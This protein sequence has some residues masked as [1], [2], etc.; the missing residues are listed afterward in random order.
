VVPQRS[1]GT[2]RRSGALGPGGAGPDGVEPGDA[3][4]GDV[5]PGADSG[6]ADS[7]GADS[8]GADLGEVPPFERPLTVLE[9][10][11][12]VRARGLA[13]LGLESVGDLLFFTPRRLER[14]AGLLT[15]REVA[16]HAGERASVLGTLAPPR[17][18][19]RGRRAVLASVVRDDHGTLE[20]RWFNQPWMRER[21]RAAAVAKRPVELTG[22][23][24]ETRS[25]VTLSTP[26]LVED[27][28]GAGGAS[29]EGSRG[30]VELV[31][32]Y[33]AT[34]GIGQTLL[35]RLVRQALE[36]AAAGL[37]EPL[38][39]AVR[40]PSGLPALADAVRD[41][42][43]PATVEAHVAARRRIALERLLALQARL[44][45]A[46][47]PG[48]RRR[49]R[50]VALAP[51]ERAELERRLPFPPT[52]GQRAV[53]GEILADLASAAPMRRLLQGEVG[54]GKTLVALAAAAAVARGGGQVALL[55]PTEILAEQHHLGLSRWLRQLGLAATL[56]TGSL[57]PA[58]RRRALRTIEEGQA[59]V[60][61]GTHALLS[62]GVRFRSLDLV[63]IDE[64]QRFGVAQKEALLEKG[65]GVHALLMTATPIPR[66]LALGLYADLE[67]SRLSELPPGRGGTKTHVVPPAK[68]SRAL[69]FL[70]QRL[71]AGERAFWV[72]PRIGASA[73]AEGAGA[74]AE[75]VERELSGSALARHGIELVHGRVPAD[76][77]ARRIERFRSGASRLLVGT[78]VVEVGIDVPEATVLVVDGAERFGLAQLH[79]LRGRVG[80]GPL[81]AHCLLFVAA[82]ALERVEVL[83]R[84][85]DGFAIA[86]ED[87]ASRGMG[88]LTGRR[89]AGFGA[90][91]LDAAGLDGGG[92][93][94]ELAALAHRLV[95][96]RRDLAA[97]YLARRAPAAELV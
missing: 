90:P 27:P 7:G 61:V 94:V 29:A 89:Q 77:R 52:D 22:R 53:L 5:A 55:A 87:L 12:P 16:G 40:A 2:L 86:E 76:E 25:G 50:P 67:V 42:H 46:S 26:A 41:L 21:V 38:D 71:E 81:P 72:C 78:S 68:R 59:A 8:G 43:L 51:E 85:S 13:R 66:T 91:G 39:E 80:R 34:E 33:P 88:D 97:R 58:R 11:G 93:D 82:D 63:V 56:L 28:Q 74:A 35:L 73:E 96:E 32:V 62:R 92:P 18:F 6:G 44:V 83:A 23:V 31:A 79:Q 30:T 75:E 9:G 4:P 69:G 48:G 64:Q 37:D 60:A 70:R 57:A 15:T 65:A 14:S 1:D 49:A 47:A 20:V 36:L 95:R 19:R 17:F 54:S 84:C 3:D 10:V 24:I 45:A